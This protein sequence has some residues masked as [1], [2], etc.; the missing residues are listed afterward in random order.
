ML[1]CALVTAIVAVASFVLEII[2]ALAKKT[3][4]ATRKEKAYTER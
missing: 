4:I 3:K 2:K 1:L